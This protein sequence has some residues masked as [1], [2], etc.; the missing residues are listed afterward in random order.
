MIGISQ[1]GASPD[2]AG[3]VKAATAQGAVTIAITNEPSS[4]LAESAR[5]V[6]EL[7]TGPE[8]SVAATKT[9]TASLGA[10][11]AL[12][13]VDPR[14][15][16]AHARRDRAPARPLAAGGDRRR[17]GTARRHRPR[18]P[19]GTAFEAALKLSELTGVIAAPWS[20]ADFMHG[21]IAILEAGFPILAIA[22]RARRSTGCASCWRPR[23]N[24]APTSR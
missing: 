8:R 11:A 5:H 13:G 2:V 14:D 15:L 16:A 1:S 20:V 12:V 4:L 9:Y 17:L 7:R 18:R 21:P 24:A 10:V 19:Y 22:R 6:I 23:P 3:V